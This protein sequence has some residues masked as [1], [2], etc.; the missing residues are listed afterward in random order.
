MFFNA[1]LHNNFHHADKHGAAYNL[2]M[3]FDN[4][5][6]KAHPGNTVTLVDTYE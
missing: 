6:I 5:I 1:L 2:H 4:N 3:I